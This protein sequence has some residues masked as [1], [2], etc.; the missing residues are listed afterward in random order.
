LLDQADLVV[1]CS[2]NPPTRYLTQASARHLGIPVVWGAV[3]E[4]AGRC[5]VVLPHRGPCLACLFGPEETW[6]PPTTNA[7][8]SPVCALVGALITSEALKL[9]TGIGTPLVGRLAQVDTLSGDLMCIEV[10]PDP[11]CTACC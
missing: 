9:L 8:F 2:D 4:Y 6:P 10:A 1:D 11:N 3:G 7:I 5:S